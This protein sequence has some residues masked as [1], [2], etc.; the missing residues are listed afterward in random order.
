ME[1]QLI[2]LLRVKNP[3]LG[4]FVKNK[5]EQNGFEVFFTSEDT[6]LGEVY[7]PNE[8]LLKVKANQSEKAIATLLKLHK[9]YDLNE[10]KD[11]VELQENKKILVPVKLSNSCIKLCE[12]A[13]RLAQKHQAE[14]KVVYVYPDP[15][16]DVPEKHT[17]SW[18]KIVRMKLKEAHSKAQRE[19]VEFSQQVKKQ[20]PKELFDDVKL[21]YRMLKGTPVNVISA[22][23]KR[24]KPDLVIMGTKMKRDDDGEFMGKILVKVIENV[25]FPILAVPEQAGFTG[26]DKINVLYTTDFFES[27]NASLNTL[28]D[29]LKPYEKKIDCVH[30]E[31]EDSLKHKAKADQLNTLLKKDYADHNIECTL[32]QSNTV[33]D[34]INEFVKVNDTDL[35]SFSRIRHSAFYRLF[36]Q[37]LVE[38]LISTIKVPIL[39]LPEI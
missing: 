35:V 10:I 19:L 38:I 34:G 27:D 36:H 16:F 7:N 21:H 30:I 1:N 28:L 13:M 25:Q 37:D 31:F 4:S 32:F 6:S 5:L 15:T 39:V 22:A 18:E 8:V 24:Y 29:L 33:A 14:I 2:T 20:I 23:C 3:H 26:K 12:Y 11:D 17:S 9:E